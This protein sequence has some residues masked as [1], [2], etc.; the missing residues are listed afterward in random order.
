MRANASPP[1]HIHDRVSDAFSRAAIRQLR[2][3]AEAGNAARS[4]GIPATDQTVWRVLARLSAASRTRDRV[5]PDTP[6][7]HHRFPRA[8]LMRPGCRAMNSSDDAKGTS[9]EQAGARKRGER[10]NERTTEGAGARRR[11]EAA[12]DGAGAGTRAQGYRE[13]IAP[14]LVHSPAPKTQPPG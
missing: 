6:G 11:G 8:P 4:I 12:S 13:A 14:R 5:A 2:P 10:A 9:R 3:W 1:N 7:Q